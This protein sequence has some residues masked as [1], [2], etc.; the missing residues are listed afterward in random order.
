MSSTSSLVGSLPVAA[1]GG[2]RLE[3]H[4]SCRSQCTARGAGRRGS[5][6]YLF[7]FLC[8]AFSASTSESGEFAVL[9]GIEDFQA[10]VAFEV[11][12]DGF[13]LIGIEDAVA[14]FVVF[15][16]DRV[17]LFAFFLVRAFAGFTRGGGFLVATFGGRERPWGERTRAHR[18]R[19]RGGGVW[20]SWSGFWLTEEVNG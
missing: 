15:G 1:V 6:T 16:E 5:P 11:F 3:A 14:V 19:G 18:Q 2:W 4:G 12:L 8:G 9:V 13:L 7:F 17:L 20:L 10:G